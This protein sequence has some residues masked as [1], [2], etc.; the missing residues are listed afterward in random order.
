M[1]AAVAWLISPGGLFRP[2]EIE[3]NLKCQYWLETLNFFWHGEWQRN[4]QVSLH[5]GQGP[6]LPVSGK[7]NRQE[8]EE[9]QKFI[10]KQTNETAR[11]SGLSA[12]SRV[13]RGGQAGSL[14]RSDCGV[15]ETPWQR[16][17]SNVASPLPAT[18]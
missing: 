1:A 14:G 8:I 10:I 7:K 18:W 5:G 9:I 13:I 4:V 12:G 3:N 15:S 2:I 17:P 16:A 11:D 6:K